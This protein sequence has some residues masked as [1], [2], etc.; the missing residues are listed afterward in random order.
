MRILSKLKKKRF[1]SRYGVI[2]FLQLWFNYHFFFFHSLIFRVLNL[3]AFTFFTS[4]KFG[5]KGNQ[6]FPGFLK[7]QQ[8]E[9][10]IISV[11]DSEE[12]EVES[13]D[14]KEV[15]YKK[16]LAFDAFLSNKL[17]SLYK[18]KSNSEKRQLILV[19]SS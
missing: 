4:V 19:E 15:F 10:P 8:M 12:V 11:E 13:L 16:L 9:K 6:F 1:L 5:L 7:K 14:E 2:S 3:R 18:E 17:L